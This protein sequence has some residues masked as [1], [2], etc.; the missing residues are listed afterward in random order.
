MG[1]GQLCPP[2]PCSVTQGGSHRAAGFLV[3]TLWMA[4]LVQKARGALGQGLPPRPPPA[5]LEHLPLGGRAE[6]FQRPLGRDRPGWFSCL[7]FPVVGFSLGGVL[8]GTNLIDTPRSP[9]SCVG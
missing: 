8:G 2:K 4:L 3:V 6:A 7:W 5:R 9:W 1:A